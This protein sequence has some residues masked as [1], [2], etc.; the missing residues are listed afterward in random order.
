MSLLATY[1][2]CLLVGQ[3]ISASI[4]LA[5]DRLYSPYIGLMVFIALYFLMFWLMWQVAVRL[6]EPKKT[7]T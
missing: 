6:T 4:G 5:I 7:I 1:I 2:A 3:S